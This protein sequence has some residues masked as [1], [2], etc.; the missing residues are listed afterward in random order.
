MTLGK[1]ERE[2][3]QEVRQQKKQWKRK[4]EPKKAAEIRG[5]RKL[6]KEAAANRGECGACKLSLSF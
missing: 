4:E 2:C 6:R 3:G 5:R 1:A